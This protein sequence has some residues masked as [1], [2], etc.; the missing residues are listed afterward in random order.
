MALG[1]KDRPGQTKTLL[2]LG[3]VRNDEDLADFPR[4]NAHNTKATVS[5]RAFY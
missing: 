1:R 4:P 3:S 2:V 5:T